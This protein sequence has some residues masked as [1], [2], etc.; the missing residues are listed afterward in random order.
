MD[1]A[2]IITFSFRLQFLSSISKLL[3]L[4]NLSFEKGEGTGNLEKL[5]ILSRSITSIE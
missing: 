3:S 2:S 1:T 4:Y 5:E